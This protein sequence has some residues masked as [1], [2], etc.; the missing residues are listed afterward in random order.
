MSRVQMKRRKRRE[1]GAL[2][3]KSLICAISGAVSIAVLI[4]AVYESVSGT[5]NRL[6][7][8]LMML[9]FFASL[10]ETVFGIRY[11]RREG[12]APG[13]RIFGVVVPLAALCGYIGLYIVGIL[14]LV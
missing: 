11:S 7:T 9:F 5:K 6:M 14:N 2:S 3:I 10:C 1:K 12:F 8:G 13:A 4:A